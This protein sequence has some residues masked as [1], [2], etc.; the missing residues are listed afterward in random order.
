MAQRVQV[1]LVD[2]V[3]GKTATE[4]VSFGLDGVS[5]EIDLSDKNAKALRKAYETWISSARRVGGRRTNGATRVPTGVD[6]AAVR[7][8]ASSNGYDISSRGRIPGEILEKY[9]AAGN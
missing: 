9:R 4:T 1:Q 6:T 2:D 8:W 3:D 5:Y 7:A